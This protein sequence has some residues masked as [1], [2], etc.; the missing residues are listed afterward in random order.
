MKEYDDLNPLTLQVIPTGKRELLLA[1]ATLSFGILLAS[2]LFYHAL[3]LG[4]AVGAAGLLLSSCLY[5]K[6]PAAAPTATAE[7]CCF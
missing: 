1:A 6:N 2:S 3:Q 5:L 4:F 7:R